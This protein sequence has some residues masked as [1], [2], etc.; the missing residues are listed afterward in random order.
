MR[1]ASASLKSSVIVLCSETTVGSGVTELGDLNAIGTT[2]PRE[3]EAKW[4][5]RPSGCGYSDE[6]QSQ[7]SHQNILIQ[8]AMT[9]AS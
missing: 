2:D 4:E 3:A 9:M 8:R 6:W 7:S 5:Q 1:G